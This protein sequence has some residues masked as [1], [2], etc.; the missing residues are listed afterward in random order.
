MS[1]TIKTKFPHHGM[2]EYRYLVTCGLIPEP[3]AL[4]NTFPLFR[5][6][7]AICLFK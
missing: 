6:L 5:F 2:E 1:V 4:P 7:V 3:M